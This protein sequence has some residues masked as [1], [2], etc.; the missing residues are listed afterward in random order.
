M[1]MDLYTW[2]QV[3]FSKIHISTE[4]IPLSLSNVSCNDFLLKYYISAAFLQPAV[5]VAT[6]SVMCFIVYSGLL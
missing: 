6:V 2:S 5:S 3:I 1:I 4:S